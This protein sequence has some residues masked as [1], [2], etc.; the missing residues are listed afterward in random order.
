MTSYLE[1]KLVFIIQPQK[2]KLRRIFSS[3]GRDLQLEFTL[4]SWG[5]VY[6]ISGFHKK[7]G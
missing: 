6:E 7:A 1:N 3:G 5:E 4:Q 2:V